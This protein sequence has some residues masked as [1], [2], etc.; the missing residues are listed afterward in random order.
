MQLCMPQLPVIFV[1]IMTE[2]FRSGFL[3]ILEEM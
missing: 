1:I 2:I 3:I